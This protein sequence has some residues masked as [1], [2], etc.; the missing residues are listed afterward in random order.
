VIVKC[1]FDE[2]LPIGDVKPHPKNR[3][4]HPKDQ[5][6]R[7]AKIL[8]YQGWRYP[9]K[10]S[11]QTGFVTSGHGRIEA[12]RLN[13]WT[14]VPVNYQDYE[15][16]AQE[17]ADVIADNAIASWA[18]LNLKGINLDIPALGP[19]LD[20]NLLGIRNFTLDVADKGNNGD[21][22]DAPETPVTPKTKAGELWILG[23]HYLL[24]GD[25]T[26]NEDVKRVMIGGR[27]DLV[28]TDPPY[29]VAYVGKTEDALTIEND[30][31]DGPSLLSFLATAFLE[32][33]LKPGGVF[34]VC[35]PPGLPELQFRTALGDLVRQCIVWVK[36]QFVMGRQDYH[37]RHESILY[38]WREGAAHFFV[39]DRTQDTVW[40]FDRPRR[41]AEHP[42][43]KPV[44]LVEKAILNSSSPGD[45]VF[46]GFGG[47][48]TTLIACEKNTRNCRMIEFDPRYC[49]VI[50]NRWAEFTKKDPVR[51]DGV[52]WSTLKTS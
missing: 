15:D 26:K 49:D 38:G 18:E 42:T 28:F 19:E 9:V 39:K 46:D 7:L 50:L 10:I 37:W 21:G 6:E 27:A 13:G 29:G 35:A 16:E 47:S 25:S 31:L 51:E 44:E 30:K 41:N 12:A 23:N 45:T 36:Q 4:D 33:P 17:Y 14:E 20:I 2:L 52:S 34:Y 11:N 43:M 3:N 5:I 40:N 1:L 48:G 22:N 8:D 32:W 24:C